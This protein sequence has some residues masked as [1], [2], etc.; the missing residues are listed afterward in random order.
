M[1]I[2]EVVWAGHVQYW[3]ANNALFPQ[4]VT[5]NDKLWLVEYEYIPEFMHSLLLWV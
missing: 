2:D 3:H 1:E 4:T 5:R